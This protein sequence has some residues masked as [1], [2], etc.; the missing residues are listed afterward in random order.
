MGPIDRAIRVILGM[1]IWPAVFE[2]PAGAWGA[3]GILP[4]VTA[5][6]GYCPLYQLLGISTVGGPHRV[7]HA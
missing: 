3:L 2:G 5:L 4:L 1:A 7:R 6:D